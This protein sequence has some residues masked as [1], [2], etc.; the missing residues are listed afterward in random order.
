MADHPQPI[1]YDNI[2]QKQLLQLVMDNLPECI[3]WKDV[4]SAY[5][6]CNQ[7]F[8]DI[9]GLACPDQLIGKTDYDMPWTKEESDFYV[10]CDR[11]VM[12]NDR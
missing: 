1:E 6:G 11:R 5:L 7:K 2:V 4:N 8:A 10:L 12:H 9:A 3:F